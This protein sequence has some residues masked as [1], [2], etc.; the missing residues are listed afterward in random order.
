MTVHGLVIGFK[1]INPIYDSLLHVVTLTT[2]LCFAKKKEG[3]MWT[4]MFTWE[5]TGSVLASHSFR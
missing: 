1:K 2:G 5:L 4:A 3:V